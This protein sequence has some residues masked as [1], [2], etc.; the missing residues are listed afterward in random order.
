MTAGRFGRIAQ[1]EARARGAV[2]DAGEVLRGDVGEVRLERARPVCVPDLE[3]AGLR[4]RV[5][6]H[7]AQR[8]I[9]G[10]RRHEVGRGVGDDRVAAVV[11][12]DGREDLEALGVT[13][14]LGARAVA[15]SAHL[16]GD[17]DGAVDGPDRRTDHAPPRSRCHGF[18]MTRK[19]SAATSAR[20]TSRNERTDGRI[21]RAAVLPGLGAAGLHGHARTHETLELCDDGVELESDGERVAGLAAKIE[22]GSVIE[23]TARQR[24]GLMKQYVAMFSGSQILPFPRRPAGEPNRGRRGQHVAHARATADEAVLEAK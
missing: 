12:M 1:E 11:A 7:G 24:L 21:S 4:P 9:D 16:H 22:A 23:S 3:R 20:R 14:L 15:G 18:S 13:E 10:G 2:L 6:T 17:D 8:G 19:P 5:A